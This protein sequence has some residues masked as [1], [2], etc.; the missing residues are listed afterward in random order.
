MK[1]NF[2]IDSHKVNSISLKKNL[3]SEFR[4]IAKLLALVKQKKITFLIFPL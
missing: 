2:R 4:K 1:T 3:S